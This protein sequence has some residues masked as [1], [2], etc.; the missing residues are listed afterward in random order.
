VQGARVMAVHHAVGNSRQRNS[1]YRLSRVNIMAQG[2]S[3]PNPSLSPTHTTTTHYA[4]YQASTLACK[5]SVCHYI[6]T[7]YCNTETVFIY[8]PLP[9][10]QHHISDVANWR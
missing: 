2:L 5:E 10:D 8:I 9:P 1:G 3:T 6:S 7:Q 4:H